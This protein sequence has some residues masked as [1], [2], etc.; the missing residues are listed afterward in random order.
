MGIYERHILPRI[1]E[2]FM[3]NPAVERRRKML[4]DEVSGHVL[5]IGCGTGL[6]I[7]WYTSR[8]SSLTLT[9]PN[10]GMLSDALDRIR[11]SPLRITVCR[12]SAE[13]LP[14]VAGTFDSVVS[15]WTLCSIGDVNRGLDEVF[16][17]LRPSG[18]FHFLD[19]G[20]SPDPG[21]RL[22]QK[23]L[24]PL[25]LLFG[26]GCR[27]DRDIKSLLESHEFVIR[28][29]ETLYLEGMS[30]TA[31]YLY[32]GVAEKPGRPNP[33]PINGISLSEF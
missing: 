6:N 29:L 5:E 20:L 17:V 18:T 32:T 14:F 9:D 26:G 11:I 1:V 31:G 13:S 2:H 10:S 8:V 23:I 16:R 12:S 19:H 22:L 28:S 24:K 30:R 4:L 3:S 25:F 21:V 33:P 15:T 27:P 7:P